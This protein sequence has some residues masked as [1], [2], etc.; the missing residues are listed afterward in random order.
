MT[1]WLSRLNEDEQL[2]YLLE[3]TAPVSR[4][5]NVRP[6]NLTNL[7]VDIHTENG[8]LLSSMCFWLCVANTLNM[9]PAFVVGAMGI[10]DSHPVSDDEIKNFIET[11][12]LSIVVLEP[13]ETRRYTSSLPEAQEV[14]LWLEN[15]HYQLI[16]D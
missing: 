10:A 5:V 13:R 16:R 8:E 7:G 1:D 12:P 15:G 4:P 9:D 3:A 14:K 2:I 6:H 11:F